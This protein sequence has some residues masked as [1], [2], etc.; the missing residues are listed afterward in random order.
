MLEGE[1]PNFMN[2][3]ISSWEYSPNSFS[4]LLIHS[5]FWLIHQFVILV[6]ENKSEF[7]IRRIMLWL[8]AKVILPDIK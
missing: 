2:Y 6:Y 3:G 1:S 8:L 7:D 4:N 5:L